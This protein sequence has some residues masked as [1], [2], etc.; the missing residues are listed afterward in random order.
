M[1]MDQRRVNGSNTVPGCRKMSMDQRRVDGS[2]MVGTR[3]R[4]WIEVGL[5]DLIGLSGGGG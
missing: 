2:T 3:L 4:R 5:M 1:T